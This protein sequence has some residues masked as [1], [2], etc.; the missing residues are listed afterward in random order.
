MKQR[1]T[2]FLFAVGLAATAL[3]ST[4]VTVK[5]ATTCHPP[6]C[7]RTPSCCIAKQCGAWCESH[8]GGTPLCGGNGSGGCCACAPL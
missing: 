7:L 4:P 2:G 8:G 5:A 3:L 1:M 6:A